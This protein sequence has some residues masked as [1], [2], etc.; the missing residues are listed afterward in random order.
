MVNKANNH[1][2]VLRTDPAASVP[3]LVDE[4]W[5]DPGRESAILRHVYFSG[6]NPWFRFDTVYRKSS[7]GWMPASWTFAH[8]SSHLVEVARYTVESMEVDPTVANAD[9][10]LPIDPGR[11]VLVHTYPVAGQGLDPN[12]PASGMFRVDST[13]KWV[14]L[15]EATGFTTGEGEQLPPESPNR[16]WM[17]WGGAALGG[18]VALATG[19]ILYRRRKR[20]ITNL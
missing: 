18:I 1:L 11:I 2:L 3:Y 20:R 16:R 13:G 8:T 14:P 19:V 10:V 7:R 15:D 4:F 9:F 12:K 17:W 5:V 6:K